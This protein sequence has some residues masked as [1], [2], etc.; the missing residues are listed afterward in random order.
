MSFSNSQ[1]MGKPLKIKDEGVTI[2]NNANSVDF[3]GAGVTGTALGND[4]TEDIPGGG[5]GIGVSEELA[6]AYAIVL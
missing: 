1:E 5:S 2:V 6:I 3:T 4:V